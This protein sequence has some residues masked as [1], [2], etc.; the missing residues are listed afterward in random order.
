MA[1]FDLLV[2]G[3]GPGGYVAA[4]KAAQLGLS[5][6]IVDKRETA[7]GTCLNVGCIPSKALLYSSEKYAYAQHHFKDHGIEVGNITLKLDAM[8]GRKD[9]VVKDLTQ[10]I[11]FLFKKNKIT[12]YN[13]TGSFDTANRVSIKLADGKTEMVDAKSVLIATGSVPAIPQGIEIDESKIITSTGALSLKSVPKNMIV[14]GGGYIGLELGSVWAR[15]GSAVTVVEFMPKIVPAMDDEV[16]SSLKKI[17]EKQ[18]MTFK[19]DTKLIAAKKTGK[20]VAVTVESNGKQEELATDVLLVSVGRRPTTENLGLEK[21]A[22]HTDNRGFIPVNAKYQTSVPNVYAIGDVI[23]GPMLAHKAEEEGVAVAEILVGQHGHV[24]YGAIPGVIYTNPE[25]A[26]VGK[27]EQELKTEG[28]AYKAGKFPMSANS[29]AR[30]VGE[31]EGF[32]K[33]LADAKTDQVLGVHIIGPEAGTLIAEA[34]LAMEYGASS[35][36]IARTCHAHPTLNEAL[37]EAALA[38]FAKA[39]HS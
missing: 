32:V 2:I 4:I 23:L 33:I 16:S 31:T 30:A 19:M 10:G 21:I 8:L 3:A 26:S 6:A 11:A 7:G 9:K 22:L 37:K 18:G 1:N 38:T 35:E 36:D 15:L 17:L 14:L 12:F 20:G 39:I 34:V 5:V 13:G 25:V 29:R 24:N 28:R 27:T